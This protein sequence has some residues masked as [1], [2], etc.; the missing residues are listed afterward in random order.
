MHCPSED[1]MDVVIQNFHYLKSSHGK[2]LMFFK[3]NHLI[4]IDVYTNVDWV[5]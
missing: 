2:G 1:N 4:H 5:G 3:N